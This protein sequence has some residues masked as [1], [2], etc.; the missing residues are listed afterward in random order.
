M[1]VVMEFNRLFKELANRVEARAIVLGGQGFR[2]DMKQLI[3][4]ELDKMEKEQVAR[5][6]REMA[7]IQHR[8]LLFS[9]AL[10]LGTAAIISFAGVICF[11]ILS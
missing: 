11:L 2:V 8:K 10:F 7:E 3:S 6:E 4:E 1:N 9:I 5:H